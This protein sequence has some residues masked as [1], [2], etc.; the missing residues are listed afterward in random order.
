MK[1][2]LAHTFDL[3]VDLSW[4]EVVW[5]WLGGSNPLVKWVHLPQ[6][7]GWKYQKIFEFPPPSQAIA[8]LRSLQPARGPF[9]ALHP[10]QATGQRSHRSSADRGV[11]LWTF[12]SIQE[13]LQEKWR[14]WVLWCFVM[15]PQEVHLDQTACPLVGS[16]ILYDMDH[17]KDQPLCLVDWTSRVSSS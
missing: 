6:F 10:H 1:Y 16:G 15:Y 3:W 13:I 12:S 5:K 9:L 8:S 17:P 7:S 11:G 4:C 2:L 14:G